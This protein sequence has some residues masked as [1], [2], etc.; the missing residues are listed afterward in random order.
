MPRTNHVTE[1][2]AKVVREAMKQCKDVKAYRRLEAVALRGEGKS[3]EEIGPMMGFH[4]DWVSKL[5][6]RYRNKGIPALLEDGRRGGN[7][8]NLTNEQEAKLLKE[9][10]G[11]ASAGQIIT[12]VEI[13]KRYDEILGRETKPTF[14]YSVLKRHGWRKVMP[15]SK[16]P[17]KASEEVI[18]ASK[19]LT[20]G[21][22]S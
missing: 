18:E 5:V 7:N 4:P 21:S 10:E 3:N 11:T 16:H 22:W 20:L 9:F 12:P 6:S 15:R 14:I 17:K 8:Q 19:K 13:K 1:N 2:E